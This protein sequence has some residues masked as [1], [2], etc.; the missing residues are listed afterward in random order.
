MGW[1]EKLGGTHQDGMATWNTLTLPLN[2]QTSKNSTNISKLSH[3]R[4]F[5][6]GRIEEAELCTREEGKGR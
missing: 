4:T 1:K 2:L 5:L 3:M 6:V